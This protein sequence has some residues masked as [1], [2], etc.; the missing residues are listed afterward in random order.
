M[1][2]NNLT[3]GISLDSIVAIIG[4]V[5][6][7]LWVREVKSSDKEEGENKEKRGR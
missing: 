7:W 4:L 5:A 1:F 2:T 6:L 3:L